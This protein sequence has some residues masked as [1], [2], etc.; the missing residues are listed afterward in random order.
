MKFVSDLDGKEFPYKPTPVAK[1]V[2]RYMVRRHIQQLLNR[3]GLPA[4]ATFAEAKEAWE[5]RNE[6]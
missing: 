6:S 1:A 5:R 3:L 2:A 4:T